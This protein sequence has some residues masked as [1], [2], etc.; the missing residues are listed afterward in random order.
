MIQE[1]LKKED[2][3]IKAEI[4]K[5]EGKTKRPRPVQVKKDG[6]AK[7]APIPNGIKQKVQLRD[8]Q[9]CTQTEPN[10]KRC[11]SRR[12]IH[13]HHIQPISEGGEHSLDNLK[14]LCYNHHKFCHIKLVEE[15]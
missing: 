11:E 4:V 5:A 9:Q 8:N 1:T 13:L 3:L 6:E 12:F 10:G 7:R 15:K 2:P 14:T